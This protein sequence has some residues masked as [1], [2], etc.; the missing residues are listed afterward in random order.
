MSGLRG[1]ITGTVPT[2][3]PGR[4]YT[5]RDGFDQQALEDSMTPRL[6]QITVAGAAN[7]GV[8][9][10]G[11]ALKYAIIPVTVEVLYPVAAWP[12]DEMRAAAMVSDAI[13]L[14]GALRAPDGWASFAHEVYVGEATTQAVGG[15]AGLFAELLSIPLTA[16]WMED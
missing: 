2:Y 9:I 4:A 3:D 10:A 11:A 16:E 5:L 15:T 13:A 14:R 7:E 12:T 6:V 1:L 8:H